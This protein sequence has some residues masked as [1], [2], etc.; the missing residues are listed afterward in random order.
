[1]P[2]KSKKQA[3]YF[4]IMAKKNPKKWGPLA[5]KWNKHSKGKMPREGEELETQSG[6]NEGASS[7]REIDLG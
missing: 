4:N 1:M 5:K 7:E 2:Y 3:A 6:I